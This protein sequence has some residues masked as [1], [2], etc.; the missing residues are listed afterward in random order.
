MIR[1]YN[2]SAQLKTQDDRDTTSYPSGAGVAVNAAGHTTWFSSSCFEI[3]R[4]T[5]HA[6][7]EAADLFGDLEDIGHRG[8]IDQPV[9]NRIVTN[10]KTKE[11]NHR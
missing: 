9:L 11:K 8:W 4:L 10:T 5:D 3:L 2:D 7:H 1:V 6:G